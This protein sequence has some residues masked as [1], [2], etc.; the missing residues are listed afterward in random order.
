MQF[1]HLETSWVSECTGGYDIAVRKQC[2]KKGFFLR[3]NKDGFCDICAKIEHENSST[4]IYE[5][6]E[7]TRKLLEEDRLANVQIKRLN[8]YWYSSYNEP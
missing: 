4:P 1:W 5:F 6:S 7:S 2:G 8:D 3:L